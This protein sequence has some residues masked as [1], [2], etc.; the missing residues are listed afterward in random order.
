MTPLLQGQRPNTIRELRVQQLEQAAL[1]ELLR[2][3]ITAAERL[4]DEAHTLRQVTA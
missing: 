2:G 1:E 4:W 3:H